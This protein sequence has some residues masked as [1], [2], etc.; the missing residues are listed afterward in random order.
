MPEHLP[1]LT[2]TRHLAAMTSLPVIE[3]LSITQTR[4]VPGMG[5]KN[6]EKLALADKQEARHKA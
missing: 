3:H 1:V 2:Q 6:R 4:L 5:E